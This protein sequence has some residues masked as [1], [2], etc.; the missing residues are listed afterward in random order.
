MNISKVVMVLFSLICLVMTGCASEPITVVNKRYGT[1]KQEKTVSVSTKSGLA[2]VG[3][4]AVGG[5]LGNQVGGG[6]GK[7]LATAG[8]SIAGGVAGRTLSEKQEVHFEY[9]V[10]MQ[11]GERFILETKTSRKKVGSRVLIE[12]LSNGRERIFVL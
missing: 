4:A 1:I 6:S 11:D 2:T 7:I 5:L 12:H 9:L 3:G 10:I 8:G